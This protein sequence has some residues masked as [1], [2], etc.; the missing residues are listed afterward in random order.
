MIAI[1]MTFA[2]LTQAQTIGEFKPK[3][4]SYGV[5]KAKDAKRIY[6]TNFTV[7]YQVYNEK[8]SF[9]QGGYQ[10]G[11]GVKGDASASLSVGLEG[12]TN[13]TV[14]E[15]TD[16]L[17]QKYISQ[18]KAAGLEVV[19][20]SEAAKIDTYA[21]YVKMTG[22]SIN[23]AQVPGT[24]TSS[25]TGFEYY[26]KG[27]SK[28]GK[29]KS[30]GFLGNP[31]ML[32]A[33]ISK[34]LNDAIVS[35]VD[36]YV[37]FVQDQNAWKG[38]GANIKVKT[39]LRISGYE[40]IQMASDAKIKFKGANN[41]IPAISTVNFAHGKMGAGT[42]TSYSGTLGMPLS[43]DGVIEDQKLQ[44]F[45]KGGLDMVAKQSLYGSYFNKENRSSTTT[46]VIPVDEQKYATGVLMGAAKFLEFHTG[47]FLNNL[48]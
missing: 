46:K 44:S 33:K 11:G 42:T 35:E 41:V 10:L 14:Q 36:I 15:I 5:K 32:Y 2:S 9:K 34:E 43:I 24:L 13:K 48:K 23:L 47:A 19:S 22:G 25:P 17:Y 27:V 1:A 6:I 18:L 31:Q 4:Q 8:E 39:D 38:A 21:D 40:S 45:A 26:V 3:D 28:L 29:E 12:I 20:I 37:L 30:G 7:N 16:Q